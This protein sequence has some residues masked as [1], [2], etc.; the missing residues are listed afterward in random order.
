MSDALPTNVVT[1]YLTFTLS[2]A[3]GSSP[4]EYQCDITDMEEIVVD[5]G[6]DEVVTACGVIRTPVKSTI[7][8]LKGNMVQSKASSDLFRYLRETSCAGTEV[9]TYSGNA[10]ITE[11]ATAPE[12]GG[13]VSGW[14]IPPLKTKAS[15]G[16]PTTPF[17]FSF[18]STAAVDVT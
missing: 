9:V 8:G 12:W 17:E 1:N 2:A 11:G 13:T 16:I 6:G 18:S 4:V 10:T 7:V 5:Y 15:G 14:K 3:G